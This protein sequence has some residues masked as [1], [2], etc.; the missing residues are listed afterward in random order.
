MK[1]QV[2]VDEID[3]ILSKIIFNQANI[4]LEQA[5]ISVEDVSED[6]TID[7]VY[8]IAKYVSEA[9]KPITS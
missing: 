6:T 7:L 2:K 5:G 3:R 8:E 4:I 9:R 1:E